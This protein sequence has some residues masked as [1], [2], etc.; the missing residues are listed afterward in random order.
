MAD[1][2]EYFAQLDTLTSKKA[3]T[4]DD[5]KNVTDTIAKIAQEF[6]DEHKLST[7][8]LN[9]IM[10]FAVAH[11]SDFANALG[12]LEGALR[13]SFLST[14]SQASEHS[15]KQETRGTPG[16]NNFDTT[17]NK[18][19]SE[20]N[21]KVSEEKKETHEKKIIKLIIGLNSA[22]GNKLATQVSATQ[23]DT[24]KKA[25]ETHKEAFQ[26]AFSDMANSQMLN[27]N[28]ITLYNEVTGSKH[29]TSKEKEKF[30]ETAKR[31]SAILKDAHEKY[32][33][34]EPENVEDNTTDPFDDNT[35]INEDTL[36]EFISRNVPNLTEEETKAP[37]PENDA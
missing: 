4:Q 12:G 2:K 33:T 36:Y 17:F 31:F 26:T 25:F 9:S 19:R 21:K 27:D 7:E 3:L 22:M 10:R 11:Q 23:K 1:N 34:T 28:F 8:E 24:L 29:P 13:Q 30:A 6:A 18:L 14:L 15:K 35:P 37:S 32:A 16:K 20:L 5:S